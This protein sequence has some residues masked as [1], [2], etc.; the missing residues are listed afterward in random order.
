[1]KRFLAAGLMA[2]LLGAAAP[3][4]A[5]SLRASAIVEGDVV[6]LGDIFEDAGP[7]AET[8]VLYSPAPGRKVTLNAQWLSEVARLFQVAWRPMTMYERIVVERAGKIISASEIVAPL[9]KALL[10]QGMP[11]HSEV[12]LMNRSFEITLP[13]DVPATLEIR[14]VTYDPAGHQFNALLLAGGDSPGAQRVLVQG[15][16]YAATSIPVLRRALGAGEIIRKEDVEMVYRR[17]NLLTGDIVTDASRIVGR[18]PQFRIAAGTPIREHDTRAPTLVARNS[19]VM[20]KL[21]WGAMTLTAQGKAVDEGARGDVIRVENLQSHKTIEATI[22]GP[23]LVT[24]QI[25]PRVATN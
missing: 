12:E 22:S 10:A 1:V 16:T 5:A 23:D 24:V 13:I 6:R 21:E 8:P 2:A 20:I 9:R 7:K 14:N 19:Q 17:D 11:E 25:G 15:R 4:S 3:V 18:T